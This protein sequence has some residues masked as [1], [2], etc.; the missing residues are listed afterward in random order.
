MKTR[1][2]FVLL[3][4][5]FLSFLLTRGEAIGEP[6]IIAS[7][8]PSFYIDPRED[9]DGD[10]PNNPSV[11]LTTVSITFSEPVRQFTW[12]GVGLNS[13]N[14]EIQY[15][16]NGAQILSN[17]DLAL[18]G[19]PVVS[20]VSGQGAGPYLLSLSPR[21][22]LGA[23]MQIRGR[24]IINFQ[25][26][27]LSPTGERDRVV[28][29]Y[30]PLDVNQSGVVTGS[31][32]TAYLQYM[33][34]T[35]NPAPLSLASLLDTNRNGVFNGQDIPRALQLLNGFQTYIPWTGASLGDEPPDDPMALT[36]TIGTDGEVLDMALT[37]SGELFIAGDFSYAGVATGAGVVLDHLTGGRPSGLD[38]IELVHGV[39]YS[40]TPDGQ[41]GYYIGGRFERIGV[42][43][44]RNLAHITASGS[45]DPAFTPNP[46][47][48]VR[49]LAYSGTTLYIGGTF[50]EVYG[51][52]RS[53]LAA[54]DSTTLTLR[55]WNPGV[56]SVIYSL[57]L[58]GTTLFVGGNFDMIGG[59]AR[60]NLA[61]INSETGQVMSWT[62]EPNS[63]VYSL[64]VYGSKLYV[65]GNFNEING[66]AR[67]KG[68]AFDVNS[69][70]LLPWDPMVGG[71]VLVVLPTATAV[72]LGGRIFSIGG[73]G[74]ENLASVDTNTGAVTSWN[75]TADQAV[76]S[77]GTSSGRLYAGGR[78]TMIEGSV[79][80]GIAAFNL[81]NGQLLPWTATS[82]GFTR[83][84][85][86][87]TGSIYLGGFF[88]TE[89]GGPRENLASIDTNSGNLTTFAP[90]F[91]D[92]L[93]NSSISALAV[94]TDR[95]FI[96]GSFDVVNS[97]ARYDL[98]AFD[99]VTKTLTPWSP[100][101][102]TLGNPRAIVISGSNVYVGGSFSEAQGQPRS[103]L[104]AFNA[105]D[106]SLQSWNP[107]C[108]GSVFHMAT[109]GSTLYVAGVFSSLGGTSRDQVGAVSTSTGAVLPWNPAQN[110]MIM[111]VEGIVPY[112]NRVY[113]SGAFFSINGVER[114]GVVAVD[115]VSG[116]VD[117]WNPGIAQGM[118][119]KLLHVSQ[120][121]VYL[122]LSLGGGGSDNRT[123]IASFDRATGATKWR[124]NTFSGEVR[125]MKRSGNSLFVG[126]S[127]L[128]VDQ[129]SAKS[130]AVVPET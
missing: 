104:A 60:E 106:G 65:G 22:P 81:S 83:S 95:L 93:I 125:S 109:T 17:P 122:R 11:G 69:L 87:T 29:G 82:G 43:A 67:G 25:G 99:L 26:E 49:A 73:L 126:G 123:Q 113:F 37:P 56:D 54:I 114:G 72:Y 31:D 10:N 34:Q 124:L 105:S 51:T 112:E 127:F 90:T 86:T 120:T 41:G 76:Y 85:A 98:A 58:L 110:S 88:T 13:S 50:S 3:F 33:N 115:A 53:A 2:F 16:R 47:G 36:G 23:W 108:N 30:L 18:S 128:Q 27:F 96:G 68:A 100:N 91:A 117:A 20:L 38:P 74:R 71:K 39:V 24:N 8:P 64:A 129:T 70:N 59:L 48:I 102:G 119:S 9:R 15:F 75:P 62:P 46:N 89:G 12:A 77:I 63:T 32:I 44:V 121:S 28:L 40:T 66:Q 5:L 6:Y 92:D 55:P 42:N 94:S 116:I 79:R 103:A 130:I 14:F 111:A 118:G 101:L 61:A 107:G 21:L 80:R 57:S 84:I 45:L 35:L 7:D 78:F 1:R 97:L 52:A 4:C 19:Q